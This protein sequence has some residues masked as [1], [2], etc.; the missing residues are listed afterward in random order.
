MNKKAILYTYKLQFNYNK[1]FIKQVIQK[2]KKNN[3][4]FKEKQIVDTYIAIL[5]R[6]IYFCSTF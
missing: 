2:K 5:F 3:N 6:T 1:M 4:E